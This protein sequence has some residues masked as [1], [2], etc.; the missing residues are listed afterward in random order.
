MTDPLV[1]RTTPRKKSDKTPNW[2]ERINSI[3]PCKECGLIA[4]KC[5]LESY[6][7]ECKREVVM[8]R[9]LRFF[10]DYCADTPLWE[11]FDDDINGYPEG[12]YNK[13]RQTLCT[14]GVTMYT[15]S[16][17]E[18][19]Q[20]IYEFSDSDEGLIKEEVKAFIALRKLILKRL[21]HEIGDK[22]EIEVVG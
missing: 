21:E 1:P 11:S 15:L 14:F 3:A 19:L 20:D 4:G 6:G 16:L 13:S 12:E 8:K 7:K 10:C 17:M 22:F 9:K 18:T 2:L 5:L